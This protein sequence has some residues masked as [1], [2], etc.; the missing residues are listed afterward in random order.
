LQ[1]ES[2]AAAEA[3]S[4]TPAVP[5]TTADAVVGG[6][7]RTQQQKLRVPYS[8]M[9][10]AK[11]AAFGGC[12]GTITGSVFGFMDGMRSASESNVLKKAS[13]VAKTKY[14]LEGTTRSATV[15]GVFFSGFH[16]LKYGVRCTVD[17]G[18]YGEIALAA[19]PAMGV[20]A[21]KQRQ[22]VPYASMLILMDAI[23]L[24][25]RSSDT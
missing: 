1:K 22:A 18:E 5:P 11:Q 8:H 24:Y 4:S 10:L 9:D 19:V 14:L 12:I 17:P 20:L 2:D 6:E 21:Y 25:M 7:G 13:N 23:H 3:A 15:Y 16:V